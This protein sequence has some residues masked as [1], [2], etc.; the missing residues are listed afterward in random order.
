ML[1]LMG[2][3]QKSVTSDYDNPVNQLSLPHDRS[4]VS[5]P[6]GLG[7]KANTADVRQT[8]RD[9]GDAELLKVGGAARSGNPQLPQ[10]A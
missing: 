2:S 4:V 3:V 6:R 5:Q 10:L 8:R 9:S 1:I 7:G